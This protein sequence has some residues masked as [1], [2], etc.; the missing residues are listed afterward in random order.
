MIKN[1]VLHYMWLTPSLN[2][3]MHFTMPQKKTFHQITHTIYLLEII[4]KIV[5][6]R[7]GKPKTVLDLPHQQL[8]ASYL[9]SNIKKSI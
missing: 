2:F 3:P 7:L 5:P 4:Y 9:T 8:H 6:Y 1:L